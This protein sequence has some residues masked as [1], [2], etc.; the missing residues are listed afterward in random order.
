MNHCML[1][2]GNTMKVLVTGIKG[3]LGYDVMKC[4]ENRKI[5]AVGAD[6]E[7]FDI[8]NYDQ[9]T[10]FITGY[11]PDAVIHCSAF[12]AVDKA[13]DEAE[14]C[15]K[16]NAEGTRNIA[17]VC[18]EIRAKMIY[19]S[20][21]YVFPGIG[22]EIYGTGNLTGPLG[23]YG[24]TKLQGE[25][26][27]KQILDNYFIV[28]ISWVFGKNGNNFVK[29]MLR[30]GKE[31]DELSVVADQVGSP[32]YTKD[33]APLLCDMVVT[34]KYGTYHATNEGFCSWADFAKEIFKQAG[35]NTR[36]NYIMSEEYKTRAVRP[37]NSRMSKDKLIDCGFHKLPDWKDALTR[38]L[39]AIKD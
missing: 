28:R 22:E 18:K 4:L 26:F 38:Y 17:L 37:K 3:Q 21:D 29:T 34:E 16:V 27:L 1:Q 15:Y 2:G 19:I 25:E 31:N 30:L 36:V 32:T 14:L 24:K 33:L 8:T 20:T 5:E 23:V 11:L 35:L 12:T 39:H 13:E 6:I 10:N 7:Q 9:T